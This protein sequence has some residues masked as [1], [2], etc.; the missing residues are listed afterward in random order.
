MPPKAK[1]V[2]K[3]K[4][5]AAQ[6]KAQ[7]EKRAT[8]AADKTF[9]LKNKNKSKV[10]Q[11]FV[12][13][14]QQSTTAMSQKDKRL[15]EEKAASTAKA[16]KAADEARDAELAAMFAT[17][18]KQPKLEAGVDPKSVVCEYYR[19]GKCQKGFKCKYSHDLKVERKTQK[20]NLYEDK[21]TEEEEEEGMEDWDQEKLEAAIKRKHGAEQ[22]NN[23]TTIICKHF[24]E[25]VESKLYGW[26][27]NCPGGK[28]CKYK[29]ALP[30]GYVMKSEMQALLAEE[31]AN[32]PTQEEL[33]EG[34]R[35][36]LK[37]STPVTQET[38]KAWKWKWD[39]DRAMAKDARRE[40]NRLDDKISGRD[41]FES[42][43]MEV[44]DDE[45][46]TDDYVREDDFEAQVARSNEQAAANLAKVQ[47]NAPP[48]GTAPEDE[49]CEEDFEGME[50]LDEADLA[51]LEAG[52]ADDING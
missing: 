1:A 18:I 5:K 47:S 42:G 8:A 33:L 50:D 32:K 16:K 11:N 19:A 7:A 15:Q 28:D 4:E 17:V 37:A 51:E 9:G 36:E 14:V 52:I 21:K 24:L 34:Q 3:E 22:K 40:K 27:W 6:K 29:H 41:L 26:F 48:H 35:K 43:D 25:A 46:A 31:R 23:Q 10:V 44:V 30:P 45:F 39:N 49:L 2:D 38:Y 12:K 13:T 20:K